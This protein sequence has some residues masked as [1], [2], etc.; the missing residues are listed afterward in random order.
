MKIRQATINDAA[1][2]AKVH[3]DCWRTT[4][5]GVVS[6]EYLAQLNDVN[7][8][9][10]WQSILDKSTAGIFVAE[11]DEGY[12]TAFASCGANRQANGFA[13][14]LYA[15]YIL[16][17]HQRRGIGKFL[18]DK[19]ASYLLGHNMRS[20]MVCVLK[21]NSANAFY[22]KMGGVLVEEK[23]IPIGKQQLPALIYGWRELTNIVLSSRT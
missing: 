10:I 14:E 4:Y 11:D 7:R 6:D 18:F 19:V 20:M 22:G 23:L 15:I 9:K 13:G 16:K 5:R 12:I 8:S 21:D 17:E 2:I 1:G 3:V